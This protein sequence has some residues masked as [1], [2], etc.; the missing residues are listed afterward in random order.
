[1]P[2]AVVVVVASSVVD[3]AVTTPTFALVVVGPLSNDVTVPIFVARL[4]LPVT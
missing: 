4:T 1:M 2:T 3:V